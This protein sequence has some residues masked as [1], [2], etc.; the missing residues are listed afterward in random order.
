MF[1][2]ESSKCRPAG[3]NATPNGKSLRVLA[4]ADA[5]FLS[6]GVLAGVAQGDALVRLEME[7]K[8]P[9]RGALFLQE[10]HMRRGLKENYQH[11]KQAKQAMEW[12]STQYNKVTSSEPPVSCRVRISSER[13]EAF[14]VKEGLQMISV[15]C[16][17]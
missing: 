4:F 15:Q 11:R 2:V 16:P 10:K 7:N 1:H 8:S 14:L 3:G 6:G 12:V 9:S 17:F 13:S 5:W